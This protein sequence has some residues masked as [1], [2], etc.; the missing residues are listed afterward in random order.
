MTCSRW[1]PLCHIILPTLTAWNVGEVSPLTTLMAWFAQTRKVRVKSIFPSKVLKFLCK[2]LKSLYTFLNFECSG[3]ESIRN[4]FWL[5]NTEY[6]S[7]LREVEGDLHKA[8]YCST[9]ELTVNSRQVNIETENVE[10]LVE[11]TV[12]AFTVL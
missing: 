11:Q 9:E 5:S 4:A 10:R 2:S 8:F 12:Q 6:K 3:L 7:L 1:L